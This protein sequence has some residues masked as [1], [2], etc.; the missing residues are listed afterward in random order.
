MMKSSG[1]GNNLVL[2]P[3]PG[4]GGADLQEEAGVIP[5]AVGH[6]LDDLDL[7]VDALDRA[8]AWGRRQW[9][10]M[11]VRHGFMRRTNIRSSSKALRKALRFQLC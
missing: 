6:P 2:H 5:V 11:P 9:A 1:V 3:S 4:K 10:R 7:V 8:R